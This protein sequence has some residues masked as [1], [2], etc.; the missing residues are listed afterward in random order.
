M[1]ANEA[2]HRATVIATAT[3][4][5][6]L[7]RITF[8]SPTFLTTALDLPGIWARFWFPD[9]NQPDLEHQRGYTILSPDYQRGQFH[10]DFVL[11][12][13]PGPASFWATQAQPGD[14]LSL[15]SA[16][17][18]HFELAD[19]ASALVL[20]GDM[21]SMPVIGQILESTPN[22]IPIDV[23]LAAERTSY[24]P[25]LTGHHNQEVRFHW[26]ANQ[27]ETRFAAEVNQ[28]LAE[29]GTNTQLW[30]ANERQV[31]LELRRR[32]QS[33]NR[34]LFL[35]QGYWAQGAAMGHSRPKSPLDLTCQ[36]ERAYPNL[37]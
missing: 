33:P 21:A 32:Q 13:P 35:A 31:C 24:L 29:R 30:G 5:S 16:S 22:E 17:T 37:S 27:S 11:H 19:Q 26:L 23:V 10:V 15:M 2:E 1:S 12:T 25:T 20:S 4:G 28:I 18:H 3:I 14:Q 9:P 8:F 36:T 34:D 6:H 7:R